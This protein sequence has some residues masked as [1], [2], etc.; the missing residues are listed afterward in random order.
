M[1][2]AQKSYPHGFKV[3]NYYE[4]EINVPLH[5]GSASA[6]FRTPEHLGT[7]LTLILNSHKFVIE[8][9]RGETAAV[10]MLQELPKLLPADIDKLILRIDEVRKKNFD[11]RDKLPYS[12]GRDDR[13]IR[14][15]II[16][17][18]LHSKGPDCSSFLTYFVDREMEKLGKKWAAK[19]EEIERFF[20]HKKEINSRALREEE[21]T[22]DI[23]QEFNV[24]NFRNWDTALLHKVHPSHQFVIDYAKKLQPG[25]SYAWDHF[26][27]RLV[28]GL[29]AAILSQLGDDELLQ[30]YRPKIP[31]KATEEEN[32]ADLNAEHQRDCEALRAKVRVL[33]HEHAGDKVWQTAA[34]EAQKRITE[35]SADIVDET[36]I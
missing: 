6:R 26:G 32:L 11:Q 20:K 23:A 14:G 15:Q 13:T 1:F 36:L 9:D 12:E 34:L 8:T 19:K 30:K 18:G 10:W 29:G 31:A 25:P 7:C 24:S 17:V 4:T 22:L 35:T 3:A 2:W 16:E 28:E 21:Q 33:E 5:C 27:K